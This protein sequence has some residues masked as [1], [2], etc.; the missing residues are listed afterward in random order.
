M[1]PGVFKAIKKDKTI[2]YRSSFTCNNKHI[3]LGS[4]P[5]EWEAHTA[6]MEAVNIMRSHCHVKDYSP[7][8]A[9]SFEKYVILINLR[10]NGIYFKTP[11]FL[12]QTYFYYYFAPNDYLIFDTDDLFYYSS[13]KIMRRKGHL[14]VADY[15]MQVNILSRYGIKNHAVAGRDYVF[16][17]GDFSDFR[18]ENIEVI[19]PYYGVSLF[20]EEGRE[21]YKAKI[22]VNGDFSIGIYSSDVE[23]AIAY[24]KAVDVLRKNGSRKNYATNYIDGISPRKYAEIYSEIKIPKSIQ[25]YEL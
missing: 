2:Y 21:L 25:E 9:I 5:S 18:Y 6:Y 23:A 12:K 19:N 17:N 11:V 16:K 20:F 7:V 13:H 22:H 14:F 8:Y 4:F 10:E 15:G 3:S 1:L 24:N